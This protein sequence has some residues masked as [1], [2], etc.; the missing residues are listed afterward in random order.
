MPLSPWVDLE[1][2][3]ASMKDNAEL[4]LLVGLDA[5]V[6]MAGLFL[7]ET[8]TARIRSPRRC[9]RTSPGCRRCTSRWARDET[10]L[11][12]S[13]RLVERAEVAGVDVT[14]EVFPE[15]QHVFQTCCGAFPEATDA[16]DKIGAWLRPKLGL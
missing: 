2:T 11:D 8:A 3:G 12:D 1:G 16:V 6:M 5:L 10:L 4:D 9:T 14:L 15:M 7:G 13:T